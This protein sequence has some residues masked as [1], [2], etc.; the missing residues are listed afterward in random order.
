[1]KATHKLVKRFCEDEWLLKCTGSKHWWC[2]ISGEFADNV[3][4]G[5]AKFPASSYIED[6]DFEL[7]ELN[8]FKGNK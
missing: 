8:K 3:W 5:P 6:K 4:R 2:K 1:M 7:T